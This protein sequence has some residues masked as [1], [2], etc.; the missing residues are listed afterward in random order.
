MKFPRF[1]IWKGFPFSWKQLGFSYGMKNGCFGD[2]R[3]NNLFVGF[4]FFLLEVW[5]G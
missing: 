4:G 3:T 5:I 2:G 1:K